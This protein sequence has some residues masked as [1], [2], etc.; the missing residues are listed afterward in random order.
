MICCYIY[1]DHTYCKKFEG[2]IIT[3]DAFLYHHVVQEDTCHDSF[4]DMLLIPFFKW[5][6][7]YLEF[8]AVKHQMHISTFLCIASCHA[9]KCFCLEQILFWQTWQSLDICHPPGQT[10]LLR[11]WSPIQNSKTMDA[12]VPLSMSWRSELFSQIIKIFKAPAN[13]NKACQILKWK[14]DLSK[15]SSLLSAMSSLHTH[16]AETTYIITSMYCLSA[17]VLTSALNKLSRMSRKPSATVHTDTIIR[18]K[19][20]L[21]HQCHC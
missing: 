15:S 9:E 21:S 4:I 1:L 12:V 19:G 13:P 6:T 18:G 11:R 2:I 5:M 14:S 7:K 17:L 16:I 8:F 20:M 3:V 10:N